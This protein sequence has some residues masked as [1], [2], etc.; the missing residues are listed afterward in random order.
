MFNLL[1]M[2]TS[3]AF[4][5]K[6]LSGETIN[7]ILDMFNSIF[8]VKSIELDN[9]GNKNYKKDKKDIMIKED[10]SVSNVDIKSNEAE[11]AEVVTNGI[12]ELGKQIS[13]DLSIQI[14]DNQSSLLDFLETC[15]EYF[16]SYTS[17]IYNTKLEVS[18]DDKNEYV[19]PDDGI[20]MEISDIFVDSFY[21]DE[22]LKITKAKNITQT[23]EGTNA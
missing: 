16:I 18:Y 13:K 17:E 1:T 9:D 10:D 7:F 20:R 14:Q 21:Y 22:E 23:E 3:G 4:F 8:K 15:L 5:N 19:G 6:N 2:I 12:Y 11:C